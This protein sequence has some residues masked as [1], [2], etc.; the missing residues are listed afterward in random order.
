MEYYPAE[1]ILC[2]QESILITLA[3]GNCPERGL[4]PF[5]GEMR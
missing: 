1:V 4:F 3:G 5:F 2:N